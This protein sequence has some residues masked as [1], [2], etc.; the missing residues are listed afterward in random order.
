MAGGKRASAGHVADAP[1]EGENVP[2]VLFDLLKEEVDKEKR[3]TS[4]Y[5]LRGSIS[6]FGYYLQG[7]LN[8]LCPV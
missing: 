8:V 5:L 2:G 7:F 4:V 3:R 6:G 1:E